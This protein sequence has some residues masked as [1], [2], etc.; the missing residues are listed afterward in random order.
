MGGLFQLPPTAWCARRQNTVRAPRSRLAP[1]MSSTTRAARLPLLVAILF[2]L[3]CA[4]VPQQQVAATPA[5]PCR[6]PATP[7]PSGFIPIDDPELV[8]ASLGAPGKGALCEGAAYRVTGSPTIYRAFNSTNPQ[9]RLGM[10]WALQEPAGA[11]SVYRLD[12]EICGEWSPLDRMV[13]CQLKEGAAVVLGTGQSAQCNPFLTY[14]VSSSV[15][16]YLPGANT[17]ALDCTTYTGEFSWVP[18]P[19]SVQVGA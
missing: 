5:T 7:T 13:K 11:I 19:S 18:E 15:Q 6:E 9:S 16:L 8:N 10:W 2:A 4:T 17:D 3:G 12:Y 14:P 1:M